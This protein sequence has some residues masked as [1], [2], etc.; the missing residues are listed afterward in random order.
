MLTSCSS[1]TL[2]PRHQLFRIMCHDWWESVE[3]PRM[4]SNTSWRGLRRHRATMSSL[5]SYTRF[6]IP[7][8]PDIPTGV[9][10]YSQTPQ[11]HTKYW[12]CPLTS[13]PC[14]T[15]SPAWAPSGPVWSKA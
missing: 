13:G 12:T 11:P 2:N 14:G 15:C 9:I 1:L 5:P 10:L 7:T 6:T 3:E 4:L 8:L